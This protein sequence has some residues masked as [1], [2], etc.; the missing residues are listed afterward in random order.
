MA[1]IHTFEVGYCTH[2]ACIAVRGEGWKPKKFP[3]RAFLIETRKG[4]YLWDTGYSAHFEMHAKGVYAPYR[5]ITP[6]HYDDSVEDLR[7]QLFQFGVT[8]AMLRGILLSHFHA[9]HIAG[10]PDFP[11]IPL[12]AS[13]EAVMGVAGLRGLRA[14]A[15]GFIPTLLPSDFTDRVRLYDDEERASLPEALLPFKYGR[16]LDDSD[17]VIIVALPGHAKGHV[18]AFVQTDAGWV[19]L[20]SDSSWSSEGYKNL[21]GP[22]EI[23][24]LLQDDRKAYY[25]TLH[26]L[27]ALHLK[28]VPILLSHA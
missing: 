13:R 15:Q 19:L 11:S 24:F 23:S 8:P 9:D 20:A 27:H 10:L 26:R 16:Q 3:A 12:W 21:V 17:E 5:W 22:S 25:E 2:P 7:H 4:H 28:G 6:V 1:R 18:G 14:L